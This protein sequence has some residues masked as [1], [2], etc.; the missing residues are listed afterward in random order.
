MSDPLVLPPSPDHP[1]GFITEEGI[2]DIG[3][4]AFG[5]RYSGDGEAVETEISTACFEFTGVTKI[6]P[7]RDVKSAAAG[8]RE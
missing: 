4:T 8:E 1:F 2:R 6:L 3:R 7:F 5:I